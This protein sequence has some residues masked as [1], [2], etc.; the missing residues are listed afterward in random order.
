MNKSVFPIPNQNVI[1]LICMYIMCVCM[2][3][4]ISVT[5]NVCMLG[6]RKASESPAF[7]SEHIPREALFL[8]HNL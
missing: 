4:C 1:Y 5:V 3:V 8:A 6:S 7:R 2:Y